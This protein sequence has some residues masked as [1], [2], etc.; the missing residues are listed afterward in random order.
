MAFVCL[1]VCLFVHSLNKQYIYTSL[2]GPGRTFGGRSICR[3]DC[4]EMIQPVQFVWLQTVKQ[5]LIVNP[6]TC[7]KKLTKKVL[8]YESI[9]SLDTT[10]FW[11][12]YVHF[13]KIACLCAHWP[14][15]ATYYSFDSWER[16]KRGKRVTCNWCAENVIQKRW[17][18][19]SSIGFTWWTLGLYLATVFISKHA[20]T[21]NNKATIV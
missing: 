20:I 10:F 5:A 21:G 9:L 12:F 2:P 11:G 4:W 19:T 3:N 14:R 8:Y 13:K 17:C 1:F 16:K 7:K 18:V 15:G 6:E